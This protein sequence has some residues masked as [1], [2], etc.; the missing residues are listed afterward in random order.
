MNVLAN[1]PRRPKQYVRLFPPVDWLLLAHHL[2]HE[3]DQRRLSCHTWHLI[4]SVPAMQLY[5]RIIASFC[6]AERSH[7][8]PHQSA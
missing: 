8:Q 1:Q 4:N 6:R 5:I 7:I 3:G 2:D